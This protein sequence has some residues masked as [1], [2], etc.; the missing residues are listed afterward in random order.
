MKNGDTIVIERVGNGWLV[1]P[2]FPREGV[3]EF[4]GM[5]VFNLL[6]FD[7]HGVADAN[8]TLC[9]FIANHFKSE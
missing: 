2:E 4:S 1:H 5:H 6:E 8:T 7:Q 3:L 9:G